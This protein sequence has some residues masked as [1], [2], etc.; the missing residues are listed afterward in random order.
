MVNEVT[1]WQPVLSYPSRQ[2][3]AELFIALIERS[4]GVALPEHWPHNEPY[5]LK[6]S[7]VLSYDLLREAIAESTNSAEPADWLLAE[8]AA[9]ERMIV[10]DVVNY[11]ES[12]PAGKAVLADIRDMALQRYRADPKAAQGEAVQRETHNEHENYAC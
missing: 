10:E 12:E 11:L 9:F 3:V 8:L 6:I 2:S 5:Y 7:D 1:E 4:S